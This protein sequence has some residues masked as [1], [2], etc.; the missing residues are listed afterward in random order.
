[1]VDFDSIGLILERFAKD[2]FLEEECSLH[3][4]GTFQCPIFDYAPP[5]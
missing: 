2:Y 4:Q 5:G 1:M 3:S